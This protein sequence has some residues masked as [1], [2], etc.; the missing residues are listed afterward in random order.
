MLRTEDEKELVRVMVEAR[1]FV[2]ELAGDVPSF[3]VAHE[4]LLRRWTR[5]SDWIEQYRV[6]LQL[7][8]RLEGQAQRWS[9]ANRSRDLLLPRGTQVTQA[10][11]LLTLEDFALSPLAS[12]FVRAS[13]SRAKLGERVR[14]AVTT[15]IGI[16]AVM[17]TILAFTARSAQMQAETSRSEAEDLMTY[18]LGDFVE[19][20][21]PIGRLELL[22]DVSKKAMLYLGKAST[23]QDGSASFVHRAKALRL[24]GE[25]HANRG[26]PN[27][28]FSAFLLARELLQ[29]NPDNIA[30]TPAAIRENAVNAFMLGQLHLGRNELDKASNYLNQYLALSKDL[31][32]AS[33]NDAESLLEQ[34][35]AYNSLGSLSMRQNQFRA[36]AG[37]FQ[38]SLQLKQKVQEAKPKDAALEVD[39]ANSYSWLAEAKLKLGEL[40]SARDLYNLEEKRLR[41]VY[42]GNGAWTNRLGLSLMRQ[43]ILQAVLGETLAAKKYFKDSE[44]LF[45]QAIKIDPS[46]RIWQNRLL[47][48]QVRSLEL[49]AYKSDTSELLPRLEHTRAELARI[50][51]LDPN[52]SNGRV[53]AAKVEQLRG[54]VLFRSGRISEATESLQAAL[55]AF[56]AY[57][58]TRKQDPLA[59]SALAEAYLTQAES[60]AQLKKGESAQA[61]CAKAA[62]LLPESTSNS[63]DYALLALQ[64]RANLCAGNAASVAQ[65]MQALDKMGYREPRY[66]HYVT[67][68]PKR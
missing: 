50:N 32:T 14:L 11:E 7:R 40:S 65:Q 68:Q 52:N 45:N 59:T 30:V 24:I 25:V 15:L 37:Q 5:V 36:A 60:T 28:A 39:I 1:L 18:M 27:E 12:E 61:I 48:A 44:E 33:N 17:T 23:E 6:V 2:S 41:P 47:M 19:K 46:N 13:V 21:R 31:A 64:V 63:T 66:Q 62:K 38:L 3:G 58:E 4:A 53:L 42:Q 26:K 49:E 16:M 9:D 20:L 43:G 54:V 35:Y 34:S 10:S 67:S 29:R 55:D 57:W 56:E 22:D 8:S 51:E